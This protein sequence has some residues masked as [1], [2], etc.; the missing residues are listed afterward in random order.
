MRETI[1]QNRALLDMQIW[2]SENPKMLKRIFRMLE[3]CQRSPFVGIAKPESLKGNL[4]G[5]WSRR[6]DEEHRLVYEVTDE[7]I[8]ILSARGHYD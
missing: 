3:E 7:A 5:Y 2:A 4:K 8:I 1:L 6:I